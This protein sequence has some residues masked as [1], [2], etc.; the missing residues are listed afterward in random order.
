VK[1]PWAYVGE[2]LELDKVS[3]PS[4]QRATWRQSMATLGR[5][6]VD[7]GP[8]PLEGLNPDALAKAVHTALGAGL[9]DDLDWL[10][11]PAAGV[12]LYALAAALP[13]GPEQRELG[14]RVV[15]RLHG[16]TAETFVAMATRMAVGSGKG[17]GNP[18]VRARVELVC[19]LPLAAGI[20]DG[21]L[22]LGLASGRDLA[23]EWLTGPS[24][25]SLQGRRFAARLLERA[26]REAA[27]RA[28]AGDDHALR[29]FRSDAVKEAWQR[30]LEDRESL[31]WRHVATARGLIAPFVP[32][33]EQAVTT[34]IR[35][36]RGATD[37]RRAATSAGAMIAIRPEAALRLVRA[38]IHGPVLERDRGVAAALAWGLA[39]AAES[40]PE[41]TRDALSF[42]VHRAPV[43]V[44]EGLAEL[45]TELVGLAAAVPEVLAQAAEECR[46]ALVE[47]RSTDDAETA[48]RTEVAAELLR[49]P[50]GTIRHRV[51]LALS[52]YAVNG[53]RAA[54]AAAKEIVAE[55]GGS[56]DTL[57]AF[58]DE[59]G[60]A[61]TR[62]RRATMAM[63]RDLDLGVLERGTV[64]ALLRAT[65]GKAASK[66]RPSSPRGAQPEPASDE[67]RALLEELDARRERFGQWILAR[68]A[69]SG[70]S[71]ETHPT[72]RFR[73]LRTLVHLVDSDDTVRVGRRS[74]TR[75]CKVP[76]LGRRP[77]FVAPCSPR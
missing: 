23:R 45:R 67:S 22:A 41:A 46:R 1:S 36:D 65:P 63:L 35:G 13:P 34:G 71:A 55:I 49:I 72:L 56:L 2:L 21:A 26:A 30:L 5:F 19:D 8:S 27:T 75:S 14:R 7:E 12:A 15:A 28:L 37:W 48:L 39:R 32:E 42:L 51:A 3:D 47:A 17:L 53:S 64:D 50:E 31:V 40:E 58:E 57:E 4:E 38:L 77:H 62:A 59:E 10:A 43:D 16:G 24:T 74:R 54:H 60:D 11:A 9:V 20:R 44:A 25:G 29:V 18:A 73:R 52:T 69:A 68:E 76:R 6:G 70:P 66:E 33:L 61:G